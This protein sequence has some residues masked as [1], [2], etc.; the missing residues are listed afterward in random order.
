MDTNT[1]INLLLLALTRLEK[2]GARINA[3]RAE[4]RDL[5][6]EEVAEAGI[7]ADAALAGLKA[8]IGG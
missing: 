4:G 3:A 1:A 7:E 2:F 8:K 5:T 6:P